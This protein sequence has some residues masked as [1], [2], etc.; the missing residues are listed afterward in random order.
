MVCS[1]GEQ[2]AASQRSEVDRGIYI[3]AV[4]RI[5]RPVLSCGRAKVREYGPP[6]FARVLRHRDSPG[7]GN[8]L[9][10]ITLLPQFG[11]P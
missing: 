6:H 10:K 11:S 4:Q 8:I 7:I 9:L 2:H 1:A 5:E 3:D